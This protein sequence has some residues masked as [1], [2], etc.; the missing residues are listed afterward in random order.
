MVVAVQVYHVVVDDVDPVLEDQVVDFV[1]G[2]VG[3]GNFQVLE[4]VAVAA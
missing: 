1:V 2:L 4:Q 3:E